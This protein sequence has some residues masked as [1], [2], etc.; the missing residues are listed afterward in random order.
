MIPFFLMPNFYLVKPYVRGLST[1]LRGDVS[2]RYAFI[3]SDFQ[4]GVQP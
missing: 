1:D 2:Y 3:D 4:E